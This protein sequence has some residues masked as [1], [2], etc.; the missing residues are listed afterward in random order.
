MHAS[1]L[2]EFL[3]NLGLPLASSSF[4]VVAWELGLFLLF[5][6][7]GWREINVSFRSVIVWFFRF[8]I[9]YKEYA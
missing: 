2:H 8:G 6:E 5:G 7:F 3:E 9:T 1:S 4:L